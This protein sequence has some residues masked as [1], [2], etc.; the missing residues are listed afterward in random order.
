MGSP[1]GQVS[2]ASRIVDSKARGERSAPRG[3]SSAGTGRDAPGATAAGGGGGTEGAVRTAAPI[4][5][6]RQVPDSVRL[7]AGSARA[8]LSSPESSS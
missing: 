4:S 1:S 8:K 7:G 3:A 6:A 2:V 5:T